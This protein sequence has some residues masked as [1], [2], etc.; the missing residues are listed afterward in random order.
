MKERNQG[1]KEEDEKGKEEESKEFTEVR[2]FSCTGNMG[3]EWCSYISKAQIQ[4]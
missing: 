3:R 4:H 2:G 1:V